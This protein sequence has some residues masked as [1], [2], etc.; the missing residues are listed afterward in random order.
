MAT[1][2]LALSG[3]YFAL[4][5]GGRMLLQRRRT[6]STGFRGLHGR[7]GS[8]EWTAGLLFAA[9]VAAGFAAPLLDLARMV[10]PIA[11]LDGAAAHAAGFVLFGAG[12]AGTLWA[13]LAMGDSWR[14]GL[15]AR[16]AT[17]LVT[18]GPFARVRNPIYSAM[19]PAT[20]G[21]TLLVPNVVAVAGWTALVV[22]LELT[23]RFV[24]ERHLL[25]AHGRAYAEYAARVGRFVPGWGRLRAPL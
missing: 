22:A 23:V 19:I 9:A 14:I 13:Q 15:D 17:A 20:L 21:I 24:E 5:V 25:R 8:V 12:L 7:P 4:A 2:A 16:E 10:S 1:W 3:L 18:R 11:I 6:G